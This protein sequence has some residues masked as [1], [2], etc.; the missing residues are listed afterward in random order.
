MI[1]YVCMIIKKKKHLKYSFL[2]FLISYVNAGAD[3]ENTT[4]LAA[5]SGSGKFLHPMVI[6]PGQQFKV[7]GNQI[8]KQAQRIILGFMRIKVDGWTVKHFSNGS[9]NLRKKQGILNR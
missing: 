7:L 9:S 8:W 3:Q 1:E 5:C 4:V 2:D 6:F